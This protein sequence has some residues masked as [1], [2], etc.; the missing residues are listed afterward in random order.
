MKD[1]Q[2]CE[3]NIVFHNWADRDVDVTRVK[4]LMC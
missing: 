4:I 1:T 3:S 2:H